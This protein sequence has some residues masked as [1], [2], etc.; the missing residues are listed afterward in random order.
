MSTKGTLS[1]LAEMRSDLTVRV[2][3]DA[4]LRVLERSSVV[5]LTFRAVAEEAGISERTVFRYFATRDA[6]LDAIAAEATRRLELPPPP[7]SLEALYAAPRNLYAAFEA[8]RNLTKA[9]VHSEFH[10]RM[11]ER[12]RPRWTAVR[13]LIDVAMPRANERKR[14]LAATMV[15]YL[16]SANAW[17]SMR[18]HFNLTLEESVECAESSVRAAIENLQRS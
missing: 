14:K 13:R 12:A 15:Q 3:L 9:A 4:A 1:K 6:F 10:G 16:L 17:H 8:E 2:V 5:K 7:D 11:R 18:F